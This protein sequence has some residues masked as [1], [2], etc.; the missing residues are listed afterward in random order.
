MKDSEIRGVVL[1]RL[2]DQRRSGKLHL[3][4]DNP[5]LDSSL[6]LNETLR[7]CEQ[8]E[9]HGL[10]DAKLHRNLSSRAGEFDYGIVQITAHGV[11]VVEGT[12]PSDIKIEFMQ[13]NNVS[14]TGSTG[15]IVGDHNSQNVSAHFEAIARQIESADV[16]EDQKSEAKSQL[17]KFLEN[18]AVNTIFGIAASA[19]LPKIM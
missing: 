2:Y 10:V 7:I 15:V 18:P 19:L 16:S 6:S 11:D 17:R 3:T 14:I 9:Q 8:L 1:Q 13:T 12:P 5:A 4:V